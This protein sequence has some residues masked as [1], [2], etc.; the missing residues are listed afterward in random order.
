MA[1]ADTRTPEERSSAIIAQLRA[2]LDRLM[3]SGPG[4]N[5]TQVAEMLNAIPGWE[6]TM[7]QHTEH[8]EDYNAGPSDAPGVKTR[9][10]QR[11]VE[12]R[13]L[14]QRYSD[15]KLIDRTHPTLLASM[16]EVLAEF[17]KTISAELAAACKAT[18]V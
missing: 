6:W 3:K 12:W 8:G 17:G 9:G 5:T 16:T 15:H 13:V 10:W 18:E 7:I 2:R 1:K 11:R 4:Y 14:A